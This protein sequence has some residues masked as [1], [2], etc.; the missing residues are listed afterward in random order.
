MVR[1]LRL[2]LLAVPA[3]G[4]SAGTPWCP[5]PHIVSGERAGGSL[6]LC[7]PPPPGGYFAPQW[8]LKGNGGVWGVEMAPLNVF[9]TLERGG[10]TASLPPPNRVA[11]GGHTDTS[12]CPMAWGGGAEAPV[13]PAVPARKPLFPPRVPRGDAGGPGEPPGGG[14]GASPTPPPPGWR[15]S[16]SNRTLAVLS[17]KPPDLGSATGSKH[18]IMG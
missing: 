15:R 2:F 5:P 6:W 16:R 1:G 8:E 9:S 10:P 4:S 3:V 11:G 14:G 17:K 18:G 7:P 12:G 13:N